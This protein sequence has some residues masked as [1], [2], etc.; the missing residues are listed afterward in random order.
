MNIT[1][2]FDQKSTEAPWP[3]VLRIANHEE[4]QQSFAVAQLAVELWQA[5]KTSNVKS[6]EKASPKDFLADAWELIQSAR[7]HVLRSQS[8]AE[9]LTEHQGSAVATENVVGRILSASRVPFKTLCDPKRNK[10]DS[11]TVHGVIWKVFTTE[12]G[13]DDLFWTYWRETSTLRTRMIVSR[14]EVLG[15]ETDRWEEYGKQMLA[16]WKRDGVPPNDFLALA[17]FRRE[18]DKRAANLKPKQKRKNRRTNC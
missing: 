12:R 15:N 14:S 10:G 8:N 1:H 17:K 2:P 6:I 4:F 3:S 9:Y 5:S 13:F 11:E 7:E 16:S 18:H